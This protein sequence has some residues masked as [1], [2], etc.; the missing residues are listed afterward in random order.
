[1]TESM[2][3]FDPS[4]QP[5]LWML[6]TWNCSFQGRLLHVL[7]GRSNDS[8]RAVLVISGLPCRRTTAACSRWRPAHGCLSCWAPGRLRLAKG[9]STETALGC[10]LLRAL[11][12]ERVKAELGQCCHSQDS[13]SCQRVPQCRNCRWGWGWG[14]GDLWMVKIAF[15]KISWFCPL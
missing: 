4:P 12:A 5:G 14:Q 6:R 7:R 13:L 9:Q 1:M 2:S 15:E 11:P 10:C 3:C 8:F